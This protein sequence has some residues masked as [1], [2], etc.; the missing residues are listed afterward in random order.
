MSW[1]QFWEFINYLGLLNTGQGI[2]N[3]ILLLSA[4]DLGQAPSLL[5]PLDGFFLNAIHRITL[6]MGTELFKHIKI[7]EFTEIEN[8]T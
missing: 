5:Q 2:K 4:W 8:N 7:L 6:A 1:S 3:P